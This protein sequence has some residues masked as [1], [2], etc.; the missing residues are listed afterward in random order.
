MGNKEYNKDLIIDWNKFRITAIGKCLNSA[1]DSY[2]K[3]CKILDEVDFE[4]AGDY[5]GALEKVELVYKF[6]NDVKLCILPCNFKKTYNAIIKFKD[7]LIKNGDKFIKITGLTERRNL[8]VEFKTFD[9]GFIEMDIN[10][11]NKF[12]KARQDF[13]NKLKEVNGY[14]NDYYKGNNSKINIHID[15]V[16]LNSM[17][18]YSFKRTYK[19]IINFKNILKENGDRFIGFVDLSD[20]GRLIA[21]IKTFDGGEIDIDIGAYNRFSE[22]RQNTYNYCKTKGYKILSPYINATEK[23]L[24]DFNCGHNP[25]W[26]TP[27]DLRSNRSCPICNESKGE[28]VIRLYLKKNNIEFKRECK[29]DDCKHKK[30]LPFDFYISQYN[31]CIEFDGR[32]HFESEDFFGGEESFRLTKIR[33]EIKN[34]YCRDNGINLLRIP[35]YELDNIEKILDE[36]FERLRDMNGELEGVI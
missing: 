30:G 26:I 28:Q 12:I 34:N 9:D 5:V 2:I 6:N 24:I 35:Y 22:T 25:N 10:A 23:M 1:K 17:R 19:S 20:N 3:F 27:S 8:K 31:L 13:Y 7:N 33:D 14:T 11:Y 18:P 29:F 21:K 15:G 4:L 16:K 36:E 32:Q